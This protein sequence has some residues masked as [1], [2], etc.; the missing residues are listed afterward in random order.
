MLARR[1]GRNAAPLGSVP[2]AYADNVAEE[3]GSMTDRSPILSFQ[4]W[5]LGWCNDSGR[6]L[7]QTEYGIAYAAFIAAHP[8]Q[9]PASSLDSSCGATCVTCGFQYRAWQG[10][11]IP[12]PKCA[13]EELL[14]Q[15]TVLETR[16]T[17]AQ[18]A[19][20]L[21]IKAGQQHGNSRFFSDLF[22]NEL[23]QNDEGW[24]PEYEAEIKQVRTFLASAE[25][26]S[27]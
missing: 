16:E 23:N 3:G 24:T 11:I 2:L 10:R 14:C 27:E 25:K 22:Y 19:I 5:A 6:K 21:L 4:E 18:Q 1:T 15:I 26:S 17:E 7:S 12:C 20:V 9:G 8:G 13:A